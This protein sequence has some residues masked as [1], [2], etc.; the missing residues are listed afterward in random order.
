MGFKRLDSLSRM[1][2]VVAFLMPGCRR[3]GCLRAPIVFGVAA[4]VQVGLCLRV[5]F[6]RG[7]GPNGCSPE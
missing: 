6:G 4:I 3:Q 5:G 7:G 1:L 2:E